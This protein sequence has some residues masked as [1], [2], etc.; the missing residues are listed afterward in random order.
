[1][2]M[3][4]NLKSSNTDGSF[5]MADSKSFLS[6]YEILSTALKIKHSVFFCEVFLLYDILKVYVVCTH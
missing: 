3:Q 2:V 1:M 5:T 4:L 6:P